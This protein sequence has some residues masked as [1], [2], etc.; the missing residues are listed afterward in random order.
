MAVKTKDY[1]VNISDFTSE[2]YEIYG[3]GKTAIRIDSTTTI[4][5]KTLTYTITDDK[6]LVISDGANSIRVSNYTGIKYI[7]TDYVKTGKKVTFN[8]YDIISNNKVDNTSN[9]ITTFNDKKFTATSGTNYNDTLDYYDS[10]YVAPISGKNKD[11]GLTIKGGK[12]SDIITGTKYNDKI[13]GGSGENI[14]NVYTTKNFGNDEIVLTKG[15][16]LKIRIADISETSEVYQYCVREYI[17]NDLKLSF[18][19]EK[20]NYDNNTAVITPQGELRGTITIKNYLKKDVLTSAG[21]FELVNSNNKKLYDFRVSL[22]T[23]LDSI[24]SGELNHYD[25]ASYKGSWVNDDI[26]ASYFRRYDKDGNEITTETEGY[27]KVKGVTVSLGGSLGTGYNHFQGSRYADTVKGGNGKDH[28]YTGGGNDTYTLGKGDDEIVFLADRALD[29]DTINLTKGEKLTLNFSRYGYTT[30]DEFKNNIKLK[31]SGKN[32]IIEAPNGKSILKNFAKSNVVG[33]NGEVKFLYKAA[34]LT[35]P[36]VYVGL[37]EMQVTSDKGTW[38]NDFIDKSGYTLYTDKKKTIVQTNTAK[39]GVTINGGAGADEIIGS[40]YSDTIKAG[41]GTGDYIE[42]GTGN[43]KLYASTTKGS[44]TTFNFKAGDGKDTVYSG[45]GEDTIRFDS[46]VNP[47][48]IKITKSGKRDLILNYGFDETGKAVDTITIKN[49]YDKKGKKITTSIKNLDFGGTVLDIETLKKYADN[50]IITE[51]VDYYSGNKKIDGTDGND[52]IIAPR[53]TSMQY[54]FAGEGN[55]VIYG[56][57]AYRYE[58]NSGNNI[59]YIKEHSTNGTAVSVKLGTGNDTIYGPEQT[60]ANLSIYLNNENLGDNIYYHR[61]SNLVLMANSDTINYDDMVF[62]KNGNDLTYKYDNTSFTIKDYYLYDKLANSSLYYT[63]NGTSTNKS[64]SAVLEDKGGAKI[65]TD[66]LVGGS[67]DEYI[68]G[69]DDNETIKGND[70]N[71]YINPK[72][73]D[74]EIHLGAGNDILIAGNGDKTIY[75]DE[76]NNRINLGTGTNTVTLGTGEDTVITSSTGTNTITFVEG[77]IGDD[78]FIFNGGT[79][80]LEFKENTFDQLLLDNTGDELVIKRGFGENP[81]KVTLLNTETNN[82]KILIY[83]NMG[84]GHSR[85]LFD[86]NTTTG[87]SDLTESQ[88]LITGDGGDSIYTGLGNDNIVAGKGSNWIQLELADEG[89]N[90]TYTY[91]AGADDSIYINGLDNLNSLMFMQTTEDLIVALK[92]GDFVNNTLTIKGYYADDSTKNIKFGTRNG[93]SWVGGIKLENLMTDDNTIKSLSCTEDN[94]VINASTESKGVNI[95]GCAEDD[96]I[97][98][99]NYAD[100]INGHGGNDI[101]NGGSGDDMYIF[102]SDVWGDGQTVITDTAGTDTLRI[103]TTSDYI[104]LFFDVTQNNVVTNGNVGYTIGNDLYIN[105]NS[106]YTF[107]NAKTS[108]G[109]KITNYFTSNGKIENIDIPN[110]NDWTNAIDENVVNI[111]AQ[112]V[113]NWLNIN[114]YSSTADVAI[115]AAKKEELVKLYKPITSE[116]NYYSGYKKI[117]GTDGNDLIIAPRATS[118]QYIF[119]GE[120]N[121]VIYGTNAYRYELNS[122]NNILYIKEHSTNG[123]AVSVKLGTGNDTIYGPEQTNANLSIYLNNENL[124]DNIY[125][126]RGSNLVLMA[127]SDTINYDDMV[128]IKNGN[129]LTYKYDNTSF[130]IKDYYLYDKLA[131]SSLYYT[132]NGTSTNK[133]ISAVLEDKGGAYTYRTA[134]DGTITGD[135]GKDYVKAASSSDL[136]L[137]GGAGNDIYKVSFD[138]NRTIT[139]TAGDDIL[140]LAAKKE[141]ISL[142]FNVKQ[143]G[144]FAEGN[145]KLIFTSNEKDVVINDFDSIETIKTSDGYSLTTTQLNA[146]QSDIAGWL[147]SDGRDYADVSAALASSDKDALITYIAEQTNWQSA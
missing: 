113:A 142:L 106:D 110:G 17:N 20:Y 42:G 13:T 134:D 7:K 144:T 98:G 139:D 48:D 58:L 78:T 59:L 136:T 72:G 125:Y 28:I 147:G 118:M 120:G 30:V 1:T 22:A 14:I 34:T 32:L 86:L 119:A 145:D 102:D 129:D 3:K 143:D 70:G 52:L 82:D 50:S 79:N 62:I 130:T 99:S 93:D 54:I 9:P 107:A 49:Y 85:K 80:V 91:T 38:H 6:K 114:G 84:Q 117:D 128:F 43:D 96:I 137:N 115:S 67:E 138:G 83:S 77:D 11:R 64:I 2:G 35:T 146:L 23:Y 56:T 37:D 39:K 108:N 60:N 27:E 97:T 4:D 36:A 69:T 133:S 15:E 95:E 21:S 12:G 51:E 61:G 92:D 18:Y 24:N 105:N 63:D 33:K 132:D 19:S 44:S 57:N 53:A 8:L 65:Y 112:A 116:I 94:H 88:T 140:L 29:T 73:G 10:T 100:V 111:V 74:D 26:R 121:D 25:K 122:G 76:G 5:P 124:G 101:I 46:S 87:H 126:H 109:V 47:A 66:S 90:N 40:N 89:N 71:D 135:D 68:V 45:K 41:T 141:D 131:N 75:A 103:D 123:T 81:K 16:N 104:N 127:N 55:D 31:V